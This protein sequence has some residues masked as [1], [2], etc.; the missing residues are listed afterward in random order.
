[1][2]F[3]SLY[4]FLWFRDRL[5]EISVCYTLANLNFT[6]EEVGDY[7]SRGLEK[8]TLKRYLSGGVEGC[9]QRRVRSAKKE[10]R[11]ERREEWGRMKSNNPTL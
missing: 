2:F 3:V 7:R 4:M 8:A 9:S 10:G 1:M 6:K 11:K 5:G